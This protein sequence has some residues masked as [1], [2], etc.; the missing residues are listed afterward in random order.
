MPPVQDFWENVAQPPRYR[1]WIQQA[2]LRPY[3]GSTV[4]VVN[5]TQYIE[6]GCET[7]QITEVALID[8]TAAYDIVQ[9][10]V[11]LQKLYRSNGSLFYRQGSLKQN[12]RWECRVQGQEEIFV[13]SEDWLTQRSVLSCST[14]STSMGHRN[15]RT[16]PHR[17]TVIWSNAV[18]KIIKT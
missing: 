2:G 6:K 18:I 11:L 4:Q 5:L 15:W 17:W 1:S 10:N 9:N 7:G 16:T 8:L 3:K 12:C 14:C 13:T